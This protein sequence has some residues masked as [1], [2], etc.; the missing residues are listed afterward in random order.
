MHNRHAK[1]LGARWLTVRDAA[2]RLS[3]RPDAL[4]RALERRARPADDGGIEASI[5]GMRARKF[6]RNWRIRV[7]GPWALGA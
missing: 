7:D 6:A 5:D 3:M 1:D 2:D 4:R